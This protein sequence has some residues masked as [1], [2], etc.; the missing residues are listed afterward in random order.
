M[1]V[2]GVADKLVVGAATVEVAEIAA[3]VSAQRTEKGLLYGKSTKQM[4][5]S[6]SSTR[7]DQLIIGFVSFLDLSC[8]L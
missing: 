3:V 2:A 8:N 6:K 7:C 4:L 1:E 5:N